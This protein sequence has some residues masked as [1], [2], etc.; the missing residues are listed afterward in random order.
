MLKAYKY[1]LY[2]T[3]TQKELIENHIVAAGLSIIGL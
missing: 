1:K 2:P 3:K